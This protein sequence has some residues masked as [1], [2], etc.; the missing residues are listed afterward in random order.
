MLAPCCS[1]VR[2]LPPASRIV[3]FPRDTSVDVSRGTQVTTAILNKAR[4]TRIP[5]GE[6]LRPSCSSLT[7]SPFPRHNG[8]CIP[9]NATVAAYNGTDFRCECADGYNGVTCEL[10]IDYCG[11]ITCQNHGICQTVQMQWKCRCLDSNLY[12][13]D[14]CQFKSSALKMREII[15]RSFAGVA[16]GAITVTCGFVVVMDILKYAFQ[17]DPVECERE[18]YRRRRDLHREARRPGRKSETKVALRFQYVA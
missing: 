12:T 11:N 14:Y 16:I 6:R 10:K 13:G 1:R 17:I 9:M 5:A 3:P 18:S 7:P 2:M 15:S 8:T 4:V